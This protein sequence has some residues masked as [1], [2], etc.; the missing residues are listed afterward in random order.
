M[1]QWSHVDTGHLAGASPQP[2]AYRSTLLCGGCLAPVESTCSLTRRTSAG[3]RGVGAWWVPTRT[4]HT[5]TRGTAYTRGLHEAPTREYSHS[6]RST[7]RHKVTNTQ[8]TLYHPYTTHGLRRSRPCPII[9]EIATAVRVH[10]RP[11]RRAGVVVEALRA[12]VLA[13]HAAARG[14]AHRLHGY[15][16]NLCS[17]SIL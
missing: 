11:G 3:R 5:H 1:L 14:C 8:S 10:A 4:A 2:D 16:P 13:M 7:H 9:A 6:Q 12:I 17:W 15:H